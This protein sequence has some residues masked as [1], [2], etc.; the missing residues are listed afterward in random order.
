MTS[1]HP[2]DR[3]KAAKL[4]AMFHC[5]LTGTIFVYQGQEMGMINVP[6]DWPESE[7]KDIESI[8]NIA[9]EREYRRK[10]TGEKDPDMTD[11]LVG[12]RMSARD[13]GRTPV[14]WDDAPNAGF[15]KGKPW[16]RVHDDY[17]EW[18][19]A[20]QRKDSTSPWK[21]W[22]KMLSLRKEYPALVYGELSPMHPCA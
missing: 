1:D 16:M 13:N 10:K 3:T 22:Q 19:I 17:R 11:V 8:Q 14:Q 15:S 9:G 5:S 7:Y 18:N 2:D 21:F 6:R 4:M 12:M 20:R